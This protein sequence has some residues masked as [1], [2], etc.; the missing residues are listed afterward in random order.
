MGLYDGFKLNT[1]E[2]EREGREEGGGRG[3]GRGVGEGREN[4]I[5]QKQQEA[6]VWKSRCL[7]HRLWHFLDPS[8]LTCKNHAQTDR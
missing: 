8:F 5:R 2:V 7:K 1:R 4:S 3:K 6:L